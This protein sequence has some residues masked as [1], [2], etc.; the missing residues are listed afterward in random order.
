MLVSTML[1]SVSNVRV[2]CDNDKTKIIVQVKYLKIFVVAAS[3]AAQFFLCELT[4]LIMH[5]VYLSR[6]LQLTDTLVGKYCML[7]TDFNFR[8]GF[9]REYIIDTQ[10]V[11]RQCPDLLLVNIIVSKEYRFIFRC[12]DKQLS[13]GFRREY[14]I[15]S[16]QIVFGSVIGNYNCLQRISFYLQVQR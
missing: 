3:T 1:W 8:F 13:C 2:F 9:R 7:Y 5:L 10:T 4:T 12:R 15:D 11:S 16:Q 6:G 14:I